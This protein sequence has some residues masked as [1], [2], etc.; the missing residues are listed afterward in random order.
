MNGVL[1]VDMETSMLYAMGAWYGFKA[2]SI[3]TV[4]DNLITGAESSAEEREKQANDMMRVALEITA[5]AQRRG[6]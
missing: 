5:E 2:L 3:L 1:G 4:S 6:G